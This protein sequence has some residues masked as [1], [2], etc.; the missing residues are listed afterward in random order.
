[1]AL[2]MIVTVTS[3]GNV[4]RTYKWY[5]SDGTLLFKETV[6]MGESPT[7]YKLP[8]DT[9]KWDYIEWRYGRNQE[10]LF[11][12]RIP[13]N[14]YFVGNVFQIIIQD[15][16]EQPI[17]TG[18]AFVFN[19][20]GWFVTNAHVM[21]DAYY[22]QAIFNIPNN[23]TGESFTYLNINSGTYYHLDKDIYIGKIEGYNS[24][25]S[26]YKEFTVNST[27]KTGE[28]TYSIGYPNSSTE[29]NINEG[30]VTETW[31]NIYDKLYS[32][33]SY[34]CSSSYIAP[35]SSGG[36]LVN[37]KFEVIGITTLGWT[38]ENDE[39]IS[40]AAIS[41]FNFNNLLQNTNEQELI[42]LQERFHNDEKAFI[43]LLNDMKADEAD[44]ETKKILFDDGSLAYEYEYSEEINNGNDLDYSKAVSLL[45]ATDGWIRYSTEFYWS[46]GD[47]RIIAF[48]GYYDHQKG[49]VN[50]KYEFKYNWSDG[51]YYTVKCNNINYSPNVSLTLNQCF[52]DDHSNNYT[53]SDENITYA[54]EQFN[55]IYEELTD[56][57]ASYE[58]N[59]FHSYGEWEIT[60]EPNCIEWG[61]KERICSCGEKEIESIP[62]LG[63]SFG[64]WMISQEPNC[65]ENGVRTRACSCGEEESETITALGHAFGDWMISQ[66][67]SCTENGVK[68]R[69][70]SCGEKESESITT[71]GHSFGDWIQNRAPSCTEKGSEQRSCKSCNF[72][73]TKDV[74]ANGHIESEFVVDTAATIYVEGKEHTYCTTCL[75]I[76]RSNVVIPKI[77]SSGFAYR[78]DYNNNT[79]T[80]TGIGS[81]TDTEVGIPPTIRGYKVIAIAD[82]AFNDTTYG[83]NNKITGIAI[84][85]SVKNIGEYAFAACSSLKKVAFG[86]GI[87]AVG[88]RA[89][90]YRDISEVYIDDIGAWCSISFNENDDYSHPDSTWGTNLYL[91]GQ[92]VTDLVI[93]EGVTS[94]G[95]YAFREYDS[96]TNITLPST[97]ISIE[98]KAFEGCSNLES[99][100]CGENSNLTTIG[101]GAFMNCYHL[102]NI[103]IPD[104]VTSI[105]YYTFTNTGYYKDT[106]NWENG[107]LYI[108]K[109]LIK[110]KTNISGIYNIKAGTLTIASEAFYECT[111]LTNITISDNVTNIGYAAFRYCNALKSITIPN[112][113][114]IF[115]DYVFY[116]CTSLTSIYF[117]GTKY[118]WS[119]ISK[120]SSWAYNTSTFTI[121]CTNGNIIV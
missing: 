103:A 57:F 7:R 84:P 73:E 98:N 9:E 13:Q 46:N 27:Y 107:V 22:A 29:L 94:I 24:L 45:V 34:I 65:T 30:R 99:I 36:I 74:N 55:Y 44:G 106:T 52:V 37:E 97:L 58:N 11:A 48:Y 118:Q 64:E 88:Y 67:P 75:E 38:D 78:V 15:L 23:E 104:S 18:S 26:Y 113:V 53:P 105:G 93:P 50:F 120:G 90:E 69:V 96:I 3:C 117:N 119:N 89:F 8:E 49:F 43:G 79:C 12:Y 40:G 87:E 54:R 81:C 4:E 21:E 61:S 28:K 71:R 77:V 110:A 5:D 68:T 17:A 102:T 1:M 112:S 92:L 80:I 42:S 62:A 19:S 14:S 32:G 31:S 82:N 111:E 10:E 39:F 101:N 109:H 76:M 114:T 91:K 70:C 60:K 72:C 20:D 47:R 66:E 108:G 51:N 63:H 116:A 95:N 85:D 35:G 83:R 25:E 6:E 59:H 33:N 2:V 115:G 100:I 86:T 56:L 16:A 41:A 121:Y